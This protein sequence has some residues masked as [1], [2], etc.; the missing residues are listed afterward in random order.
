MPDTLT[1][2]QI[3]AIRARDAADVL[4]KCQDDRRDLL[5]HIDTL[6]EAVRAL[7]AYDGRHTQDGD[8]LIPQ[9]AVLAI[10]GETEHAR[11]RE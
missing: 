1:P 2:Q 6:A 5:A 7:D 10:L 9:S 4:G 8:A 3:D 11:A